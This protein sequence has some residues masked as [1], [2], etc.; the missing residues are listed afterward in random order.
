[1]LSAIAPQAQDTLSEMRGTRQAKRDRHKL[2]D[3]RGRSV[4]ANCYGSPSIC[5]IRECRLWPL[6]DIQC[7]TLL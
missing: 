3:Q 1:M 5:C 4:H 6:C 2:A 7:S